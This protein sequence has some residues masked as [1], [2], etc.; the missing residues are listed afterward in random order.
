MDLNW[1]TIAEAHKGLKNKSFSALE[2]TQACLKQIAANKTMNAFVTVTD[3]AALEHAAA[4]DA[5]GEFGI[6][7]GIPGAIKDLFNT[8]GVLSTCSSKMLADFV[9]P[10]EST[11]TQLLKDAGT[12]LIGKTNLDEFAC[13]VSTGTSYYGTTLNPWDP[14]YVAGGSSGGSAAAVTSGQALFALGTDT[15]GS[16]RQPAAWTGS[17]GLKP[18]YGRISRFGVTALASSW[19][20]V[21]P[22]ARTVEDT[23][24]LLNAMAGHDSFDAT[25]PDVEVPDYTANLS[26]GVAGL[27][28][29]VPK[30]FFGE[31]IDPEVRTLVEAAIKEYEKMGATIHEV[32]LPTMKY[33]VAVYYVTM[34]AELS[35]NLARFD[36]VRFG[37][38]PEGDF[39]NLIDYYK[40]S[41]GEGFGE[42]IKRRIMVGTFVLSAGYSDAYYKQGQKVRTLIIRD[43]ERVFKEVDVLVAPSSPSL[44]FKLGENMDDPLAMYMADLLT[45]PASAAGIPAI[46]LPCGMSKGLPVGLQVMGPMWS[47]SLILQVAAAYEQA[48]EWHKQFPGI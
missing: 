12:V 9:P 32:S 4:I 2:L 28:V 35:A 45:I 16:I 42:E 43:F 6:L 48:T 26:K 34:P 37:H 1:L 20:T 11:A 46:S 29:G 21:G 30:E 19:D 25:T 41:R 17:V 13:G 36:G 8:K 44:A 5:K 40:H 47:E 38:K 7:T 10:Y 23:A 39:E 14:E 3:E 22:M 33:G 18:T 31:G 24:I 15:G 27:K